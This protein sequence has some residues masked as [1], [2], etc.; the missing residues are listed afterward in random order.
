MVD[1][2]VDA[3]RVEYFFFDIS[4]L[5][6]YLFTLNLNLIF[7]LANDEA[8]WSLEVMNSVDDAFSKKNRW[9]DEVKGE[10]KSLQT[11]NIE[12][13]AN[14]NQSQENEKLTNE[15]NSHLCLSALNFTVS[16]SNTRDFLRITKR[17]L[18]LKSLV[19][20]KILLNS[21]R[22]ALRCS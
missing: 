11:K 13:V 3:I 16:F 1:I 19:E 18:M 21:P 22:T 15:A 9:L 5:F 20:P 17:S 2:R 8:S 4:T 10:L 7:F 12:F 14:L 6:I